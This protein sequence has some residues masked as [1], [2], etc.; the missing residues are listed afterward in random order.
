[1]DLIDQRIADLD[2]LLAERRQRTA[3]HTAE[4]MAERWDRGLRTDARLV[5]LW[6]SHQN[7]L[8]PAVLASSASAWTD[9]DWLKIEN[10][11]GLRCS[12]TVRNHVINMLREAR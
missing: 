12:T 7:V 4:T 3:D 6:L 10:Q 9:T 8:D 1:M 11:T 2:A 5:T